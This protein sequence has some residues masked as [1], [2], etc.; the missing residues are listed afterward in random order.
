MDIKLLIQKSS[1]AC[2]ADLH[3]VVGMPPMVRVAGDIR[4]LE[5]LER[6]P[7]E[8]VESLVFS[9]LTE[10]QINS[11]KKDLRASISTMIGQVQMRVS[12]Y[13]HLGRVEATLRLPTVG[14]V[15]LKELGLPRAVEE[16]C[17]RSHGLV[18]VTGPTGH[19]KTTTLNAMLDQIN[20]ERRCKIVTIEDPIEFLHKPKKAIIVQ[21]E[22][23]TDVR[24]FHAAL[25]HTLRLD[26]DVICVGEM[27]DLETISTALEAAETGHLVIATLHTNNAPQTV[28]RIVNAFPPHDR[29]YIVAQL[30]GTLQGIVSQL[31]LPNVGHTRRV[32]ACEVMIANEAVRNMIRDDKT[33]SL[34]NVIMTSRDVG[35]VTMDASLKALAQNGQ[36]S[37]AVASIYAMNPASIT[38]A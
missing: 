25:V 10:D 28:D 13:Y 11:F 12:A 6:M 19:G 23:G 22:L 26:P 16:L 15:P 7:K 3:L 32:M 38:R 30:A 9:L 8:V 24:S 33:Q 21:Q 20:S 36:I 1:A 2:A 37:V 29:G 34:P 4:P 17:R 14:L 31:L 35:M 18:L 5:G 27:R